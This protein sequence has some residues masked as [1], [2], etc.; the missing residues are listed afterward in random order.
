MA[1]ITALTAVKHAICPSRIPMSI[2]CPRIECKFHDDPRLFV[3]VAT[4]VTHAAA[5]A[6][7]GTKEQEELAEQTIQACKKALCRCSAGSQSEPLVQMGIS[8]FPDR[9]EVNLEFSENDPL[10]KSV[11][12][13]KRCG[14]PS[15]N[16]VQHRVTEQSKP[17]P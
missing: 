13:E 8:S 5:H 7:L 12:L 10:L 1:G 6:G 15:G 4:I 9:I 3:G 2:D 16:L 14:R 17:A 11:H